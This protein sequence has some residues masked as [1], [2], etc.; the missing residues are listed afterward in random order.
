MSTRS[1]DEHKNKQEVDIGF[2]QKVIPPRGFLNQRVR[3]NFKHMTC[4]GAEG[5][6][7]KSCKTLYI[8]TY[9]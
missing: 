9:R 4:V 1:K 2:I 5:T 3:S 6:A 7:M 8:Q